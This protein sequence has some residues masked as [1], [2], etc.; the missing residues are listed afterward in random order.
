MSWNRK[1][2]GN[3]PSGKPGRGD[4]SFG[5]RVRIHIAT[6]LIVVAAVG[7]W[8]WRHG[9]GPAEAVSAGKSERARPAAET[10]R[11]VEKARPAAVPVVDPNAR[12]TRVGERV[13]NYVMLPSGRIHKISGVVTNSIAGRRKA[14]FEIFEARANNE[15]AGYLSMKPGDVIVEVSRPRGQFTRDFAEALREPIEVTAEDTPEQAQLKRDV[16]EARQYLKEALGRGEDIEQI[17]GDTRRELHDMMRAK[18]ELKHLFYEER[19]KCET[20]QEVEELF[21]ACNAMLEAK[22]IAPLTYGPIT[23]RMLKRQGHG[24]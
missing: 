15:L 8:V 20:D 2:T 21:N 19:M 14:K 23:K 18:Q 17:I 7:I 5:R 12:P 13:N 11:K 4:A 10:P 6:F 1:N 22:G 9:T 24:N 3:E 16:L